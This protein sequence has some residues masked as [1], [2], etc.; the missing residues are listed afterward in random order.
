MSLY[1]PDDSMNLENSFWFS[2]VYIKINKG[3]TFESD[4]NGWMMN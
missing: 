4:L 2:A 1:G 3:V